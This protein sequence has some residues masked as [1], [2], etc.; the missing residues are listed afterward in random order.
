M[1]RLWLWAGLAVLIPSVAA[2]ED[3]AELIQRL[4]AGQP[5][6]VR[7][8]AARTLRELKGPDALKA[9]PAITRLLEDKDAE[10]REAGVTALATILFLQ[11]QPCPTAVVKALFDAD[12]EVRLSACTYVGAFEK[13]PDEARALLLRALEHEDVHVR[14]V[15]SLPLAL[16]W[17]KEKEVLDA[18]KKATKDKNL[19]A[20]NN[21]YAALWRLTRDLDLTLPHLL[22]SIEEVSA[23]KPEDKLDTEAEK[24]DRASSTLVAMGSAARLVELT[25]ERPADLAK[26]CLKLLGDP[27]PVIRRAAVRT[28]G[29]MAVEPKEALPLLK[30]GLDWKPPPVDRKK[31]RAVLKDL[32]V[33]AAVRKLLDDP[34]ESA[35]GN[36]AVALERLAEK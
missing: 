23:F 4:E 15:A 12:A 26:G 28:L 21:A 33:E 22:Q 6:A 18:L 29:A 20:R 34:D 2:A 19:T 1:R 10:V 5:K 8:E 27:S 9:V 32:K 3:V 13:F 25:A 16:A 14:S 36:A 30:D 7:T 11:K 17:G 35:R 31:V 24:R